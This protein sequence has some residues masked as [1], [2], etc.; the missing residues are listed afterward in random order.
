MQEWNVSF[1]G[2]RI[3][4]VVTTLEALLGCNDLCKEKL[5]LTQIKVHVQ[6]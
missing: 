6:M 5:F 1:R 4:F 3:V 2:N